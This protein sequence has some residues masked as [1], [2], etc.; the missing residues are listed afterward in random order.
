[1]HMPVWL[2]R[3]RKSVRNHRLECPVTDRI[4]GRFLRGKQPLSPPNGQSSACMK[5]VSKIFIYIW[6]ETL[7]F[8]AFF[9]TKD[10]N[11][12]LLFWTF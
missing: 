2:P 6:D 3:Q 11:A 7:L 8:W 10:F 1:M 5:L 4:N 9:R 12:F